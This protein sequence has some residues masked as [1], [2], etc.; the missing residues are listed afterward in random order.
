MT[1]DMDAI[2]GISDWIVVLAEG[3]VIAEGTPSDV[4]KNPAVIDAYLGSAIAE[5]LKDV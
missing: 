5:E 4:S 3:Q 1:C 2:M